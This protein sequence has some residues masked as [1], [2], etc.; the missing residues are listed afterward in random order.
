MLRFELFQELIHVGGHLLLR[1]AELSGKEND[2]LL[3]RAAISELLPNNG[4]DGIEGDHVS[5]LNIQKHST[6]LGHCGSNM[7]WDF[8]LDALRC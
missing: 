5:S 3:G 7:F 6:V 8:H 4:S 2:D 1:N